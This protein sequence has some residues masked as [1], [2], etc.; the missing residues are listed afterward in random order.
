MSSIYTLCSITH[1]GFKCKHC[2][3][4]INPILENLLANM[5]MKGRGKCKD[6][7]RGKGQRKG[8]DMNAFKKNSG[9]QKLNLELFEWI[10]NINEHEHSLLLVPLA[11]D[12]M[13]NPVYSHKPGQPGV[14]CKTLL[15]DL[16]HSPDCDGV[17]AIGALEFGTIRNKDFI[18]AK[19]KLSTGQEGW[20][21]VAMHD[22]K[23]CTNEQWT[24]YLKVSAVD[25]ATPIMTGASPSTDDTAR[26]S[27]DEL[28]RKIERLEHELKQ[29]RANL[30]NVG[31]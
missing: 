3:K 7:G 27:R 17:M 9:F 28:K 24:I 4:T 12:L 8:C 16:S 20:I 30:A 19:I 29:T 11:R 10:F 22:N 13:T 26:L 21:N 25:R 5:P 15:R 31:Q 14:V 23:G 18:C 6:K 2:S 1:S